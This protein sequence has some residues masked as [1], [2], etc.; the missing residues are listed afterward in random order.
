MAR[1]FAEIQGQA[2]EATRL[3][4][5]RS[6]IRAHVRG[7]DVGVV[8][9]GDC[10]DTAGPEPVD[11]FELFATGGS[12]DSGKRT[13]I[14]QVRIANAGDGEVHFYPAGSLEK[15]DLVR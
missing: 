7:W 11:V 8:V 13:Y 12:N 2:G 4:S 14:G 5:K 9:Y 1:F 6:G 3:G 10:Q 15:Y